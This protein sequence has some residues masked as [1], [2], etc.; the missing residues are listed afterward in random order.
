MT[1]QLIISQ[2]FALLAWLFLT[3]SYHEK[4]KN[5]IILFQIISGLFYCVS[6]IFVLATSG[7]LIC[8]FETIIAIFY[9]KTDKDKLIYIFTFPMYILIGILAY[10]NEELF[11]LIPIIASLIDG[12]GMI[13][14]NKIIVYTGIISYILWL[15]YDLHY[16]EYVNV[17]G[18]IILIISNVSII[19]YG[20]Y[21]FIKRNEIKVNIVKELDDNDINEVQKLDEEYY[22][23]IY[24]WDIKK[25]KELYDI[26]KNSYILVKHNNKIVGYVNFLNVTKDIYNRVINDN[27][28]IDSFS[29]FDIK[30]YCKNE[31][32]YINMNSIVLKREY[33]NKIIINKLK[34][35]INKFINDKINNKYNIKVVYIYIVNDLEETIVKSM[36][37]NKI[38]NISN[39]CILYNKEY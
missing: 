15:I 17:I 31:L 13:K 34:D 28:I 23:N 16:L 20:L 3:I 25:I 29:S 2:L 5:K 12:Y 30:K 27:K 36:K 6:Y 24:R 14:N 4:R 7:F 33:N 39:E 37:F 8:L 35:C 9:Y 38:K 21:I 10:T 22:D 18:D 11:A 1:I 26:E 19:L 32:L